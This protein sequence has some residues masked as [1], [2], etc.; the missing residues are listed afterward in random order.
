M[1]QQLNAP[2]K[3]FPGSL[4][5]TAVTIFYGLLIATVIF[6]PIFGMIAGLYLIG[7]VLLLIAFSAGALISLFYKKEEKA[8]AS[9]TGG[10]ITFVFATIFCLIAG[11]GFDFF[12][13]YF[14]IFEWI[15]GAG[16]VIAFLLLCCSFGG[17]IVFGV[18]FGFSKLNWKRLGKAIAAQPEK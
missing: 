14:A 18:I 15:G 1:T 10:A 4:V 16:R 11:F 13:S 9:F 2:A 8:L 5:P 17:V 7:I 6:G 3:K 12:E